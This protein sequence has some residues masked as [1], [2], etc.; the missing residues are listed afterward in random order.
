[1]Q[2]SLNLEETAW[3]SLL[4]SAAGAS[5]LL[6][7]KFSYKIC[8][9]GRASKQKLKIKKKE[10]CQNFFESNQTQNM[11]ANK[12]IVLI[13]HTTILPVNLL[14]ILHWAGGRIG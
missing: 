4:S 1:M 8:L 3:F 12:I 6:L 7:L 11:Y 14:C 13:S 9:I 2:D 5:S 10:V